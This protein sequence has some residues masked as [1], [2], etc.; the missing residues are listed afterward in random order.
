MPICRSNAFRLCDVHSLA[1]VGEWPFFCSQRETGTALYAS[2][3][4]SQGSLGQNS[5][6]YSCVGVQIPGSWRC[7]TYYSVG[8]VFACK[9]DGT[10]WTWG[11]GLRQKHGL[12]DAVPRSSPVQVT[13]RAFCD[14]MMNLTA[15]YGLCS[16]GTLFSVGS[17]NCGGLGLNSTA[18]VLNWTQIGAA[19]CW[20]RL[21]GA[22]T[23]TAFVATDTG[24]LWGWGQNVWGELGN[25]TGTVRVSSPVQLT[26]GNGWICLSGYD[27]HVG[28]IKC[29]GGLWTWGLNN[30]GQ[31]GL[32]NAVPQ[33]RPTQVPGNEW[34]D[35]SA[36]LCGLV[37]LKRD[38]TLW[39]WGAPGDIHLQAAPRSSPVQ[40]PGTDWVPD[41]NVA[42]SGTVSVVVRKRDGTLWGWGQDTFGEMFQGAARAA[43]ASPIQI[44]VPTFGAGNA[45]N[46][47]LDTGGNRTGGN[48]FRL[49]RK[50]P[51]V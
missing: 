46:A 24:V 47:W 7:I 8:P 25:N 48:L 30:C 23:S 26:G 36:G 5:R 27:S 9:S 11:E 12:G 40:I 2:G 16:T 19:T 6:A 39:A 32:G 1:S 14:M 33:S 41:L 18:N 10:L 28:A 50:C 13:G 45:N 21:L 4:G 22:T 35:I 3:Q 29:D 49:I 31:L 44:G 15:T 43:R 17:G 37:G 20:R 34:V 38:G 51:A 42:K